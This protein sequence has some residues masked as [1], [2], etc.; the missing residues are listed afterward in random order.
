MLYSGADMCL[1][2][3]PGPDLAA[4]ALFPAC[5]KAGLAGDCCPSSNGKNLGCCDTPASCSRHPNCKAANLTGDCCPALNG[6]MLGCC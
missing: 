5:V 3:K 6:A 1:G 4:C 2:N